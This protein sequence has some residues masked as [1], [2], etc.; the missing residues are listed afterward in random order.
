MELKFFTLEQPG[1]ENL[2]PWE[3]IPNTKPLASGR[4]RKG[5]EGGKGRNNN[6]PLKVNKSLSASIVG[7]ASLMSSLDL[8]FPSCTSLVRVIIVL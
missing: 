5:G 2:P 1:F 3:I 4:E 8:V 6:S 7:L